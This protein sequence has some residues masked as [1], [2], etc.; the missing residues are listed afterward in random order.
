MRMDKP[1]V[2]NRVSIWTTLDP[3]RI[4]MVHQICVPKPK[5][6][7]RNETEAGVTL[8]VI[9]RL[10]CDN[11]IDQIVMNINDGIL[12]SAIYFYN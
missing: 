8:I 1:T 10:S 12:L 11:Q 7:L 6:N 9:T 4:L 2:S 5:Q 3:L